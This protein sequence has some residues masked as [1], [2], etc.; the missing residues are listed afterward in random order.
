M[1]CRCALPWILGVNHIPSLNCPMLWKQPNLITVITSSPQR[2][3]QQ[4]QTT[5]RWAAKLYTVSKCCN[6]EVVR[7]ML[8]SC[9]CGGLQGCCRQ[10]CWGRHMV[11]PY[12]AHINRAA[13]T[14][15]QPVLQ[16]RAVVGFRRR[17]YAA[18]SYWWLQSGST[19]PHLVHMDT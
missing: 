15:L 13:A 3:L 2:S 1:L 18:V 4:Q 19:L 8:Q 6:L 14:R 16:E 17:S 12:Q 10:S 9:R 5:C 7:V 11:A